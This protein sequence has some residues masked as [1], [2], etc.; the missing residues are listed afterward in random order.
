MMPPGLQTLPLELSVSDPTIRS[1]ALEL[2][3]MILEV[4]LTLTR[5][6]KPKVICK[7]FVKTM[8]WTVVKG[9]LRVV[10]VTDII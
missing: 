2:S 7:K 4:S 6:H 5:L 3:I 1:V 9:R 8:A 10:L